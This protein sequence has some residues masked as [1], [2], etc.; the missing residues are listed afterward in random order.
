MAK[1]TTETLGIETEVE[2]TLE[3]LETVETIETEIG[4]VGK[5]LTKQQEKDRKKYLRRK[6]RKQ[7]QEQLLT[8]LGLFIPM[9][10]TRRVVSVIAKRVVVKPSK[11]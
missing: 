11:F 4:E 2:E 9:R 10:R 1:E 5:V 6:L 8:E 7:A 3:T